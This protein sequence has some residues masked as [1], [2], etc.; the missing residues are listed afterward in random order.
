MCVNMVWTSFVSSYCQAVLKELFGWIGYHAHTHPC[1][2]IS[3]GMLIVIL[4]SFGLSQ[5]EME[6]DGLELVCI[7]IYI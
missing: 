4:S 3:T 1:S 2:Y 5:Y 7:R 6:T